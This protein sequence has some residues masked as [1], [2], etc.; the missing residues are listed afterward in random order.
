MLSKEG[1]DDKYA[2]DLSEEGWEGGFKMN[3]LTP[4]V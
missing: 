2:T 1:W 3:V 4:N